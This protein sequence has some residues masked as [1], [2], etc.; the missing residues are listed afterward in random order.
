MM[1]ST[2]L[3]MTPIFTI[4]TGSLVIASLAKGCKMHTAILS[5]VLFV[6]VVLMPIIKEVDDGILWSGACQDAPVV[7]NGE[8]LRMTS[9][10][11]PRKVTLK[12]MLGFQLNQHFVCI[13]VNTGKELFKIP[14][15][16][17]DEK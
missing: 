7:I 14:E 9:L 15:M 4:L 1:T 6:A 12:S 10:S 5:V 2:I 17:N 16:N 11:V 3:I 13:S 8:I